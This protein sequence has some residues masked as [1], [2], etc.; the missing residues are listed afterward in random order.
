MRRKSF[1]T[2]CISWLIYSL[3][4]TI[5]GSGIFLWYIDRFV[6]VDPVFGFVDLIS[7]TAYRPYVYR[8]LVPLMV[9]NLGRIFPLN[10]VIYTSAIMF[11]SLLGFGFTMGS[12]AEFFWKSKVMARITS[13]LALIGLIPFLARDGKIYDFSAIFLFSLGLLL[14]AREQWNGFFVIFLI[15]CINKET[16]VFLTLVFAIHFFRKMPSKKYWPIL[17]GQTLVFGVIKLWITWTFRNN[18]GGV[19]EFHLFD[20]INGFLCLPVFLLYYVSFALCAAIFI[21][22]DWRKKPEFLRFAMA[23]LLPAVLVANLFFG[24]PYE[25][26]AF[27]DLYPVGFLLTIPTLGKIFKLHF[28]YSAPPS[29]ALLKQN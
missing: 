19:V 18:P 20:Q 12:F 6:W 24:V 26:R 8:I 7:G 5:T 11:L 23:S 14:M 22:C 16:M 25:I 3:I 9:Q 2:K 13:I 1:V 15:G 10:P 27:M 29:T 28:S 4:L 21:I 17:M